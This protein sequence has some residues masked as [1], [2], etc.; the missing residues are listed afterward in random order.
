MGTGELVLDDRLVWVC[1]E[2]LD[3]IEE[4][5]PMEVGIPDSAVAV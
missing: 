5:V 1:D 4:G 3:E 2:I